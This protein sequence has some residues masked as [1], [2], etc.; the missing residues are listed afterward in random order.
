MFFLSKK[1]Y[2]GF[3][4]WSPY[5]SGVLEPNRFSGSH[6]LILGFRLFITYVEPYYFLTLNNTLLYENP[7]SFH[8]WPSPI[9]IY[10]KTVI[11]P[12]LPKYWSESV[13]S[14][15]RPQTYFSIT[16]NLKCI[17]DLC[18]IYLNTL[19]YKIRHFWVVFF[20]NIR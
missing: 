2:T 14:Y 3:L 8:F 13:R 7:V 19:P 9:Q 15:D 16:N 20:W 4:E 11:L 6:G 18:F 5:K 17:M 1:L 12:L 10:E